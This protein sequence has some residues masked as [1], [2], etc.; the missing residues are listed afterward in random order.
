MMSNTAR[1]RLKAHL[2][3][4]SFFYIFKKYFFLYV[5]VKKVRSTQPGERVGLWRGCKP[6][7][8]MRN[9]I[10]SKEGWKCPD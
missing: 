2:R 4:V 7:E 6:V 5:K 9:Q 8:V 1:K 10:F 3:I